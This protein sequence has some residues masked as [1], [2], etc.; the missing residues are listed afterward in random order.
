MPQAHAL[1]KGREYM[2]KN[3]IEQWK[4]KLNSDDEFTRVDALDEVPDG[5]SQ[6]LSE[7][8]IRLLE[9]SSKLVRQA[10][11][12]ALSNFDSDYVRDALHTCILRE[13]ESLVREYA[14]S[15]L[16]VVARFNDL[17]YIIE[18]AETEQNPEVL[19]HIYTGIAVA[20]RN[21]ATR[22]I[23]S[24][25]SSKDPVLKS[26]ALNA[27]LFSFFDFDLEEVLK[28][29]D[30]EININANDDELKNALSRFKK[31]QEIM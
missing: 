7:R 8:I 30:Q 27:L 19:I 21:I 31:L 17:K 10:A 16:G 4:E 20:S 22:E 2:M 11:A 26:S 5:S 15:S 6:E 12:E 29:L 25:L 14:I 18:L 3:S 13:K 24:K 9:D 28:S 1:Q 23:L